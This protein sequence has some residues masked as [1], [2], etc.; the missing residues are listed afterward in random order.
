MSTATNLHVPSRCELSDY[1]RWVNLGS[2]EVAASG[3]DA[4][5]AWAAPFGPQELHDLS[6]AM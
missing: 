6:E 1:N 4:G 3:V 2:D 5:T